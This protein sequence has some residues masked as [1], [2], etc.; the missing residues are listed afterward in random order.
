MRRGNSC[1]LRL[2][3][4]ICTDET[5]E[6]ISDLFG[7]AGSNVWFEKE[8]AELLPEAFT[9][10]HC[11]GK[12]GFTESAGRTL[13]SCVKRGDMT[14]VCVTLGAPD[15]WNDHIKLYDFGFENYKEISFLHDDFSLDIPIISAEESVYS[16]AP[17]EDICIF[18]EADA[19]VKARFELPRLVFAGGIEGEKAGVIKVFVNGKLAEEENLVYTDN[20]KRDLDQKLSLW[21]RIGSMFGRISK[22][23]YIKG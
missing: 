11:G 2:F 19:I 8:A 6:K 14:L 5:I 23:Y 4:I 20:V 18:T 12:T 13:V 17:E 1:D 21:E 9:C 16:I 22:P 7:A 3:K 10:P 15:D